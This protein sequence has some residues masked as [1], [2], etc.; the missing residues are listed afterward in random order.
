MRIG[1]FALGVLLRAVL[2]RAERPP[3]PARV[4]RGPGR[5]GAARRRDARVR[6][7]STRRRGPLLGATLTCFALGVPL[8][9]IWEATVTRVLGVALLVAFIVCGVFLIADHGFLE[10]EEEAGGR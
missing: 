1:D 8:M 7:A 5:P 4:R 2:G 6:A 10:G 9:V 3:R